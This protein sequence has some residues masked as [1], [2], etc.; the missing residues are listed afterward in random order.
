MA[1]SKLRPV[2]STFLIFSDYARGA[3]RLSALME[4][5]VIHV[6]THDSI[7]LGEDGPTHQP[8]EQLAALRAMPGLNVIRPADANEVVEA[9]RVIMEL[10]REPA[11]LV[12]TRQSVPTIDRSRYASA[13]GLRRGGHGLDDA[14]GGELP[15]VLIVNGSEVA[16]ALGAH[17]E[18]RGEGV[19]SR[20]VSLPCWELFDA[21]PASYREEVLPPS[22]PRGWRSSRPPRWA[23]TA[24]WA[25]PGR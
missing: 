8:V 3:I 21:Q 5:P 14:G 9:W 2:W 16:L 7:G 24:G 17:E 15:L 12:L 22:C 6:F 20:V 25:P 11:A 4:I 10:R 13:D 18:L 23:G 19:R 1:L